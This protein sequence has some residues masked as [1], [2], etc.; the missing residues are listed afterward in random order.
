MLTTQIPFSQHLAFVIGVAN[1]K[2]DSIST[3]KTPLNDAQLVASQ[4][5]AQGFEVHTSLDPTA[6]EMRNFLAFIKKECASH[7]TRVVIY[8][9]G[10]GTQQD[11]ASGLKGY[12]LP[13]DANIDDSSTLIA[14]QALDNALK[15]LPSRHVLLILDCCFA[16]TFR[17]STTRAAG[18]MP[19]M[20]RQYYDMFTQYPSR[21]VLTSTSSRQKALDTIDLGDKNSPFARLLVQGI[22]GLADE[23][24]GDRLVTTSELH[25]YLKNQLTLITQ[26]AGNQQS[27]EI[28]ALSGDGDGEFIFFLDG[29]AESQLKIQ[30]YDNPYKGLKSY[31]SEDAGIFFGRQKA[32]ESL[33][34]KV[35]EQRFVIVTGASGTGK[36]SLVKAGVLPRL[37]NIGLLPNDPTVIIIR[38]GKDPSVSLPQ[39]DDWD[40]LMIDQWEEVITQANDNADIAAF[41]QKIKT[42]LDKGKR[43]IGT[44]RADFEAQTRHDLLEDYWKNGRFLVPAFTPDEYYDVIVQPARRV[45]C[46]FEEASLIQSIQ[47]EVSGEPGPLPL[48][49]FL[50]QELFEKTKNET[51]R[52]RQ[53]KR[54]HYDE[55]GGFVLGF[56]KQFLQQKRQ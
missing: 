41:Y 30:D 9:A 18:K 8:Y 12:L 49:S 42:W 55:L 43:I 31:N 20:T 40:L 48:L 3:L 50:L 47:E 1:Y 34:V 22:S 56:F 19:K 38:P 4:L 46:L 44:V 35:K 15:D 7:D 2:A 17:L 11:E 6:T 26:T 45:A 36:S 25:T 32:I 23:G 5:A 53:I 24:D 52:L 10:H 21:K 33:L 37:Q 29:F 54:K 39:N 14:M 16:G 51:A 27:V 28:G 13:V